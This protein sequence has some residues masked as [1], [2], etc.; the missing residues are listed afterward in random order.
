MR[1]G[2]LGSRKTP[3]CLL[4]QLGTLSQQK[5]V[6]GHWLTRGSC[7]EDFSTGSVS[8]IE[9]ARWIYRRCGSVSG[10]MSCDVREEEVG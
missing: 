10:D 3:R 2:S 7:S 9:R 1:K 8:T 4:Q 6:S 5:L